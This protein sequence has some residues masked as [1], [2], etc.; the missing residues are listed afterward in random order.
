MSQE[1]RSEEA[2]AALTAM[3][4]VFD[5]ITK[6]RFPMG[7]AVLMEET[8]RR[9]I[10][11]LALLDALRGYFLAPERGG[12]DSPFVQKIDQIIPRD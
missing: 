6:G 7:D 2:R 9:G 8:L 5:K 11:A 3:K 10:A 12:E 4:A 1:K